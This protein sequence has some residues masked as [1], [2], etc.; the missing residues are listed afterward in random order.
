MGTRSY[1]SDWTPFQL[2]G[3]PWGTSHDGRYMVL[4]KHGRP[5]QEWLRVG[6]LNRKM[7]GRRWKPREIKEASHRGPTGQDPLSYQQPKELFHLQLWQDLAGRPTDSKYFH[8][9]H[10]PVEDTWEFRGPWE[11]GGSQEEP[12]DAWEA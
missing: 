5:K 8:I 3:D 12:R 4:A 10:G 7:V 2:S 9:H 11:T 6:E 1:F